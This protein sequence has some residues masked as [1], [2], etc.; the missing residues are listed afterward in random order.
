MRVVSDTSPISNLA[1][2]GRLDFLR[3]RYGEVLIPDAIAKELALLTRI[4]ARKSIEAA[5]EAAWIVKRD[6][7]PTHLSLADRA[8]LDWGEIA[9]IELAL[10][11]KADLLL[12]DEKKGRE[13]ARRHGLSVG[14]LLGELLHSKQRGW[15]ADLKSEIRL[16]R[17]EARFFISAEVERSI[18]A[19]AGE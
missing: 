5:V 1:I 15:I 19:E 13:V 3:Q 8:F 2:I 11:I 4:E 10:E 18:L 16:L 9:A 12:M 17:S 7:P 6:N 14:G